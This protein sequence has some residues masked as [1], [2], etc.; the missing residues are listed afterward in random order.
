[1]GHNVE[2]ETDFF[3]YNGRT[4]E[5][6]VLFPKKVSPTFLY[7][8]MLRLMRSDAPTRGV[9]YTENYETANLN[10]VEI[11]QGRSLPEREK[12]EAVRR[13][14][15]L[16]TN[17][18]V[19]ELHNLA[20]PREFTF[21]GLDPAVDFRQA[22]TIADKH[23]EQESTIIIAHRWFPNVVLR[24]HDLSSEMYKRLQPENTRSVIARDLVG[25]WKQITITERPH[26]V[27]LEDKQ[28]YQPISL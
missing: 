8:T 17:A 18:H 4:V 9:F 3:T 2:L 22:M 21:K 12:L 27:I 28:P 10:P 15:E 19:V 14:V 26:P 5:R 11:N 16:V 25:K 1:M 20:E 23:I 6:F 24:R 13:M 7:D